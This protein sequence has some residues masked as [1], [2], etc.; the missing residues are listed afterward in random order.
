[1][2]VWGK[3]GKTVVFQHGSLTLVGRRVKVIGA[4]DGIAFVAVVV[5]NGEAVPQ[6]VDTDYGW[7]ALFQFNF[8]APAVAHVFVKS[9]DFKL[10]RAVAK[11][12][13]PPF[14]LA[15]HIVGNIV[16]QG[17]FIGNDYPLGSQ[18]QC[19]KQG[20]KEQQISHAGWF[21]Q[22]ESI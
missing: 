20:T 10:I 12:E 14:E 2:K 21:N 19:N 3:K 9:L 17:Q 8:F 22:Y 18:L 11:Q 7:L 15:N 1:M 16:A 13:N 5:K 4:N 6:G